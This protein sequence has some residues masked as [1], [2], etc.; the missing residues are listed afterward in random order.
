MEKL[1]AALAPFCAPQPSLLQGVGYKVWI[2]PFAGSGLL[3]VQR[4]TI[5]TALSAVTF[6]L[7]LFLELIN[8]MGF[9]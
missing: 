9:I 5:I 2:L 4:Y 6:S 8:A 7:N 1:L 3:S